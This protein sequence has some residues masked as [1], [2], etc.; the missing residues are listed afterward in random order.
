MN[1]LKIGDRVPSEEEL[2][3]KFDVSKITVKRALHDLVIEGLIIRKQGKGSFVSKPNYEDNFNK[4][5]NFDN[6]HSWPLIQAEH[7]ILEWRFIQL[8][9][10]IFRKVKFLED[11]NVLEIVRLRIQ[12]GESVALDYTYLPESIS[13]FFKGKRTLFEKQLVYDIFKTIPDILLDYS[14]ISIKPVLA[15]KTRA[16]ILGIKIGNPLLLWERTTFSK[17]KEVIEF[18]KFFTRGDRCNYYLEYKH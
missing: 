7:K 11:R 5:F 3:E 13:K 18:S 2:C 14:R 8:P 6:S 16:E 12:K 4:F 15:D 17:D 9:K 1:E 10:E